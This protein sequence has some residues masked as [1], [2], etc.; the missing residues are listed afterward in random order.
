[1]I[2]ITAKSCKFAGNL[3][4]TMGKNKLQKFEEIKTFPNVFQ[5]PFHVLKEKNLYLKGCWSDC[6]FRNDNPIVLE[7]GCG[8]GEYTVELAEKYPDKNFIG[9][10]IKGARMYSGAK[11]AFLKKIHNAIFLRT[12]IELLP[13]FFKS[14]EVA[15]FWITFPDPQMKKTNKRLTSTRFISLY[16][17]IC[18]PDCIINLKTDSNFL[19]AY[20]KEMLLVNDIPIDMITDD[21]YAENRTE[22]IFKIKTAYERQWLARG[23]TIK[24]IRFRINPDQI[25]KEP[26]IKIE[27]DDYRS[28]NRS[29]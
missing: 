9:V 28:F 26:E 3:T 6:V 11:H 15:E 5:F 13:Y 23:M 18:R 27:K 29:F 14:G 24:Y 7:L 17:K 19:F 8:K 21:L 22:E 16:G 4:F 25:Y 1:M 2:K 12:E 10:D 20:T